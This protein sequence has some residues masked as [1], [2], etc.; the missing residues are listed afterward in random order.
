MATENYILTDGS[1]TYFSMEGDNPYS[2]YQFG[3]YRN[4]GSTPL[5]I[6]NIT[7]HLGTAP[8]VTF[9]A[10]DRAFGNGQPFQIYITAG[11]KTSNTI[12]V[13]NVVGYGSDS[14]G[15]WPVRGD[16]DPYTFTF[17]DPPEVSA[18]STLYFTWHVSG[19]STC[20]CRNY[21]YHTLTTSPIT[22]TVTFDLAGGTRTGGGALTQNVPRG[23]NATPPTCTKSGS[24]FVRWDGSYTNVTSNRTITA[25]WQVSSFIVTFDLAGGIRTGGGALQQTVTLGGSATPP[26]CSKTGYTFAGWNG[27]YT[28][29]D[30]N[31]TITAL[32]TANT[33]T[34]TYDANGG[35][36]APSSQT[37]TYGQTITLSGT[38]PTASYTIYFDANGGAVS[39]SSR[40]VSRPF[41][42]WNTRADGSGTTYAAGASY[43]ANASVTLYAQYTNPSAGSLP[44]PSRSSCQFNRWTSSRNSGSTISSSTIIS[45]NIT[46]YAFWNYGVFLRGNGG[47]ITTSSQDSVTTITTYVPHGQSYTIPDC[48]VRYTMTGE[49]LTSKEF[50]GWSTSSSGSAQYQNGA[51]ISPIINVTNLYAVFEYHTYTVTFVDGFGI[52]SYTTQV[53]YGQ[54]ASPPGDSAWVQANWAKPGY[55]FSG[56]LGNYSNIT[57]DRTIIAMW[58]FTPVWIM[59]R[60]TWVRYKARKE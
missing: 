49:E 29:V 56:W 23:G 26:T 5:A 32:W 11:G 42:H 34:I 4:S 12:T 2:T 47:T 59:I 14:S 50:K 20:V 55:T 28:N 44:T 46:I 22:Y 3:H 38:T 24:T 19:G 25:V 58:G 40:S 18:G 33:Y 60:G 41:S 10:G 52:H 30:S 27:S 7:L 17:S 15:T 53:Q 21:D 13:S 36:G 31:R 48:Y 39:P 54:P 8:E 1:S 9:T 35:S 45:G 51:T 6:P 16:C 57:S 37:K 43:T